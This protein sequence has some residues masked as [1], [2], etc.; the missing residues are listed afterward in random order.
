MTRR[1]CAL[2]ALA[3]LAALLATPLALAQPATSLAACRALADP[4]KRLACY[5][6]LPLPAATAP[7]GGPPPATAT[8]T[9]SAGAAPAA[10]AAPAARSPTA[11]F[12]F[13]QRDVAAAPDAID[14]HIE[15]R[16]DGWRPKDRLRLANGQV[17]Q[18]M[19]GSSAVLDLNQPKVRVRRGVLGAFYLEIDGTGRMPR[20]KRIE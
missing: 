1:P 5:D 4:A 15:G 10:A 18:V 8:P 17:W 3:S 14:S 9:A 6:A 19:D 2:A 16:F 20:V 13:E 11:Q 12:G 7:A